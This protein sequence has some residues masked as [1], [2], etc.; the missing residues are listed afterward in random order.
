[1][2]AFIDKLKSRI[3]LIS[4]TYKGKIYTYRKYKSL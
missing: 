1:M 4:Q 3:C 2:H